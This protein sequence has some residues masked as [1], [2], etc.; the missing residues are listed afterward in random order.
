MS[1]VKKTIKML[2]YAPNGK[3]L[4]IGCCVM[5][6]MIFTLSVF[7]DRPGLFSTAVMMAGMAQ[8][9]FITMILQMDFPSIVRVSAYRKGMATISTGVAA[10]CGVLIGWSAMTVAFLI[11]A[12]RFSYAAGGSLFALTGYYAVICLMYATAMV[13]QYKMRGAGLV[14]YY[15]VYIGLLIAFVAMPLLSGLAFR[16]EWWERLPKIPIAVS[17][18]TALAA[19]VACGGV[20]NFLARLTYRTE[21]KQNYIDQQLGRHAG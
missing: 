19:S 9:F 11:A 12:R 4:L 20:V 13:L 6:P 14:V 2:P 7:A 8:V 5:L 18:L 17:A 1:A 10:A 15:I 16:E 3:E 21:T